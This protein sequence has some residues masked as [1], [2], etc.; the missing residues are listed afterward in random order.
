KEVNQLRRELSIVTC[1]QELRNRVGSDVREPY[2]H[3]LRKICNKLD[4]TR[5]YWANLLEKNDAS[6]MISSKDIYLKANELLEDISVVDRS[7]RE[8]NATILAE[9]R[10]LD[11]IRRISC[12]GL[13]LVKLDVRQ[14]AS[15]HSDVLNE[16]T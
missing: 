5:E 12:F 4:K 1:N 14:D 8:T 2:R 15:R 13:T 11:I 9:G 7:L 16:I 10:L 6:R 3:Y